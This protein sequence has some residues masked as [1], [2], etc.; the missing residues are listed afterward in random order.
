MEKRLRGVSVPHN[1]SLLDKNGNVV[2]E[3]VVLEKEKLKNDRLKNP[4][5]NESCDF[6]RN[7]E[8]PGR[9]KPRPVSPLT[10]RGPKTKATKTSR[11]DSRPVWR[12]SAAKIVASGA[13][14]EEKTR[15]LVGILRLG[16]SIF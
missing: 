12:D 3:K 15:F 7:P 4:A 5:W 10:G 8:S 11:A 2:S 14:S 13:S 16:I 6:R 9:P 1:F